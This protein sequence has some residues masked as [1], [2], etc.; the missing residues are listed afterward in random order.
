[1]EDLLS[2]SISVS[3]L[4]SFLF[5]NRN[6]PL[7]C[8]RGELKVVLSLELRNQIVV[9]RKFGLGRQDSR[10]RRSNTPLANGRRSHHGYVLRLEGKLGKDVVRVAIGSR[11]TFVMIEEKKLR[12]GIEPRLSK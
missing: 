7:L 10:N 4:S 11:G 1:L 6:T 9:R 8:L 12:K 5:S 2:I 3:K